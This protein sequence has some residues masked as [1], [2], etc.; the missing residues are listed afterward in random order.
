MACRDGYASD[1]RRAILVH[2]AKRDFRCERSFSKSACPKTRFFE[3]LSNLVRSILVVARFKIIS[4][5]D[6]SD[7]AC[8]RSRKIRFHI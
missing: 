2:R 7:G 6:E 3:D 5:Q 1:S 8:A 4:E